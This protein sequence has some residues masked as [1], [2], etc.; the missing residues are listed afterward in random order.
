MSSPLTGAGSIL[1]TFQYMAPEQLEGQEADARTDIFAF[2]AVVYEMVTGKRAFEGKSQ[3]SLI[4]A[5]LERNPAPMS[6]LQPVSPAALDRVVTKCLSKNPDSRW[7]TARDLQDELTWVAEGTTTQGHAASAVTPGSVGSTESGLRQGA[8]AWAAAGVCGLTLGGILAT[9]A[10]WQEGPRP[11][12]A[13]VRFAIV[14]PVAQR[15]VQNPNDRQ[16]A[17]S[18][19]GTRLVYVA[20][21]A[22]QRLGQPLTTQ[23]MVHALDRLEAEPLRGI[24]KP[25]GHSSRM[26][27]VGRAFSPGASSGRCR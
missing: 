24:R 18:P 14:P 22:E 6:S 25:A 13:L 27:V 15:L 5:I 2:G 21:G 4:A 16:L 17:I 10:P 7:Q 9:W 3:A 8:L 20:S 11:L 1:G 23:L 19:D 12:P 26:T